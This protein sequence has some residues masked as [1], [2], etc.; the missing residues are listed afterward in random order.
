[1][2]DMQVAEEQFLRQYRNKGYAT[3]VTVQVDPESQEPGVRV[4][5]TGAGW[6]AQGGLEE[7]P[8]AGYDD[9][10][11]GAGLGAFY[12]LRV[13]RCPSGHVEVTRIIGLTTDTN[14]TIVGVAAA[15]AVWQALGVDPPEID[16]QRIEHLALTSWDRPADAL[17]SF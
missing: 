2:K 11:Q 12:A 15:L 9:W 17:P 8:A 14:P 16:L 6:S 4:D 3:R 5:C 1:M 7:V 10:K 13:V